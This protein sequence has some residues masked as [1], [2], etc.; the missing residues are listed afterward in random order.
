MNSWWKSWEEINHALKGRKLVLYGRSDDW[1][2]KSLKKLRATPDYI[3]DSNPDL[4]GTA[5]DDLSVHGPER[6][7]AEDRDAVYVVITTG[8]YG[9]VVSFLTANGFVAGLHFACSPEY[10]SLSLLE[11]IR[12]YS[13]E[14]IIACSDYT[15]RDNP[16][17]SRGGGGI[18]RY[19]IGPNTLTLEARGSFRQVAQAGQAFYAVDHAD[20]TVHILDRDFQLQDTV[21]LDAPKSCGIAYNAK[22]NVFV[23]TNAEHDTIS[24]HDGEDFKRLDRVHYSLGSNKSV[25]GLHHL[26]DVCVTDNHIY[27]SYFSHSGN[28]KR[29]AY[30]GGISQIPFDQ[31][32]IA[33]V[34]VVTGLWQPHSPKIIDGELCYL[35]SMRGR[36]HTTTHT[37]A[38]EFPGF[39]RGL[40]HDGRFFYVGQSENMYLSRLIST[41]NN[42]MLNAGFYLF[43]RETKASR[44]FPMFD[45]MNV[46]DILIRS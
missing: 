35:D 29:G 9:G 27:V 21:K 16:R 4:A 22:R 15:D 11:E 28:W 40:A 23:V 24:I 33:P 3:V 45:H 10:K 17:H 43:D 13:Q 46:H 31:I 44:F 25:T 39:A 41:S 6:L 1:I 14:I 30:D 26:N 36:L 37:I 12:D 8:N 32:G 18:F 34:P 2:P 20:G 7:L 42:I 19:R 38:G 5:Y